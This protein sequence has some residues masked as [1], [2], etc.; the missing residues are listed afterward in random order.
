VRG[1]SWQAVSSAPLT[2]G[3]RV[4]VTAIEGLVL[5]VEPDT[6]TR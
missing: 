4:R 5:K 2:P 3:Q 6:T 1:E